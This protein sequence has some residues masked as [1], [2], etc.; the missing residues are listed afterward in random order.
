[1][2]VKELYEFVA[3]LME[4]NKGECK[5]ELDLLSFAPEQ[6]PISVSFD[7]EAIKLAESYKEDR[8][9]APAVRFDMDK[10]YIAYP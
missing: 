10:L 6:S 4:E 5:V 3:K 2:K 1:M 7:G 9:I 8:E